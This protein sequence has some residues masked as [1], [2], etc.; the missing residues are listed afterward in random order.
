MT[1][2]PLTPREEDDALAAEYVLGVLALPDRLAAEAQIKADPAFAR[3]VADWEQRLSPL[4]DGFDEA[5][6]PDLLPRI[7]ARLFPQA[8]RPAR[9][10]LWRWLAGMAVAA[11]LAVVAIAI[12]TPPQSVLVATLATEDARLAYEVQ[13]F[14][15]RL[16]V[17][18]VAGDPAAE[19]QTHE[20]WVIAPGAAPVSLGLLEDTPL[21]VSYPTPPA[22]WTLAVSVEPAGGSPTGAPTGPVILTAVT[23]DT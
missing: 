19:G 9:S 1:D 17:T 22:G 3:L 15:D 18:R 16:Q 6:A 14:G 23:G 11:S 12:L 21:T 5:P 10:G 8:G 13:S 20:L 2:T 4:N 7:E